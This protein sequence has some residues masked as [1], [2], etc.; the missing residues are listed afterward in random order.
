MLYTDGYHLIA[1]N[2]KELHSFANSIGIP[3]TSY[4]NKRHPHYKITNIESLQVLKSGALKCSTRQLVKVSR[5][6]YF[7]PENEEELQEFEQRHKHV[8]PIEPLTKKESKDLLHK[9][10]EKIK[11]NTGK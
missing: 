10:W 6:I 5:S 1:E 11:K 7:F 9:I 4:R 3:K 2:I 8:Q